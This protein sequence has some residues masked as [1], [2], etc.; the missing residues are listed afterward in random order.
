MIDISQR[1]FDYLAGADVRD[2]DPPR[3]RKKGTQLHG[4]SCVAACVRMLLLDAGI[5][6]PEAYVRTAIGVDALEGGY[7]S[8]VPAGLVELE[9]PRPTRYSERLTLAELRFHVATHAAL[10]SVKLE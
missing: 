3:P 10:V 6:M 2:C 5:D 1:F 9:F 7:M 4:G 8:K